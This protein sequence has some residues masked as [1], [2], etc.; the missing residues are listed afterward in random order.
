MVFL[1][2]LKQLKKDTPISKLYR[3]IFWVIIFYNFNYVY[4]FT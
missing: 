3:N 1:G 4:F 2:V